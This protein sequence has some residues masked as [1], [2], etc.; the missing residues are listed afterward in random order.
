AERKLVLDARARQVYGQQAGLGAVDVLEGPREIR[1]L[2]GRREAE[3][4]V[5]GDAHGV[6]EI[7]GAHDREHRP[8][9][10]LLRD[11]VALLHVS[12]DGRLDEVPLAEAVLREAAATALRLTGFLAADLDVL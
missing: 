2:D 10:L 7:F 12:K 5:V 1:G 11:D 3:R 8:E 9:D 6:L 4:D